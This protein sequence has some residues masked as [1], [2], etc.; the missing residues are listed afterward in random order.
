MLADIATGQH[1]TADVFFLVAVVLFAL[2]T[3]AYFLTAAVRWA[4]PL[5]GL[6]LGF[7]ALAWLIL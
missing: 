7:L 4:P 5:I 3:V 2:G 6:G 1:A